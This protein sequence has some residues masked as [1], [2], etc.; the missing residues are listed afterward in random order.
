[1]LKPPRLV[2]HVR[3]RRPRRNAAIRL[4]SP[5]IRSAPSLATLI[6]RAGG[7]KRALRPLDARHHAGPPFLPAASNPAHRQVAGIESRPIV[8]AVDA[9]RQATPSPRRTLT[10]VGA[11]HRYAGHRFVSTLAAAQ[12]LTHKV[13]STRY[14]TPARR[15]ALQGLDREYLR[16]TLA[17]VNEAG[18]AIVDGLLRRCPPA[19]IAA[20]ARRR[21]DRLS[22][23]Y[24]HYVR[25][26]LHTKG[27]DR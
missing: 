23:S 6:G 5:T 22:E 9:M 2:G 25:E 8:Q 19:H 27:T 10:E 26:F 14:L 20:E 21:I 11:L 4:Q 13:A 1:M 18:A 7:R 12:T 24:L 16:V 3:I 15:V 17:T